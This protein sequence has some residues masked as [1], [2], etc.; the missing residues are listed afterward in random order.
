MFLSKWPVFCL[1]AEIMGQTVTWIAPYSFNQKVPSDV[2]FRVMLTFL[3]F[4]TTMLG[5]VNY[6][7]YS[8]L[9]LHY[10]PKYAKYALHASHYYVTL[11][12]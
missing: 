9:N 8:D 1:Q 12:L 5:F 7:L 2:D 10:P 11:G 6:K 3:E 4:Y